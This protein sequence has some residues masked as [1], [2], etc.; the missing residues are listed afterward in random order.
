MDIPDNG[1]LDNGV[2]QRVAQIFGD[3]V[4]YA[5]DVGANDGVFNSNTL[6]LEKLGWTVLCVEPNPLLE[7]D[8]RDFRKLVR[9][10]AC[11]SEDSDGS[12]FHIVDGHPSWASSSSLCRGETEYL[13]LNADTNELKPCNMFSVC[14][15]RLDRILEEAGF[16]R[17]DYL[18]VDV[19]GWE[20]EVMA[21]FTVERWKPK[22]IVL[23]ELGDAVLIP[24]YTMIE[25][26]AYDNIYERDGL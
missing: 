24:G 9:M 5:C 6:C 14:V 17:L 8:L 2:A 25:R 22:V 11:S 15:R 13:Q 1:D 26:R 19:E 7:A 21:G 16:P 23:E 18:T 3:F 4:G 12:R 10:A 20:K